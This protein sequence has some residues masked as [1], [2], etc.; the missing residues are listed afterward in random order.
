M[1]VETNKKNWPLICH[2]NGPAKENEIWKRVVTLWGGEDSFQPNCTPAE[3]DITVITWSIPEE[4]TMLQESFE[5]MGMGSELIVIPISKPFNWLDKIKKTK[6]Y[7]ELVETK[8]IMGL[9]AT[10]VIKILSKISITYKGS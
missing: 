6:E 3:E 4:S 7:L 10:D 5:K 2:G 1:R 8:Y 9:D